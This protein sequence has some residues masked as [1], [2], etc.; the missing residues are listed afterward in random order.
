MLLG[1]YPD[2]RATGIVAQTIGAQI[3]G[4]LPSVVVFP[5]YTK[6]APSSVVDTDA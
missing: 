3:R 5:A 4:Q 1:V 6:P 2:R